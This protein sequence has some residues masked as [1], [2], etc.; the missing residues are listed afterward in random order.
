MGP[1]K[2]PID[3][4]RSFSRVREGI[5]A[6][7]RRIVT[8]GRGALTRFTLVAVH[9]KR[10]SPEWAMLAG[11]V[12]ETAQSVVVQVELP[13]MRQEDV[14]VS[15]RPGRLVIRGEKLRDAEGSP[16]LYHLMERA[17]GRFERRI[18]LPP[19]L[20]GRRAEISF[21]DGIMT[22]IVPKTEPTPPSRRR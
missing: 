22:A 12:W 11:E 19:G 18:D 7:W 9:N 16:R 17:F 1:R 8:R 20:D 15:I 4:Q 13:G 6:E 14:D 10:P 5:S 21:R 3:P 2:V